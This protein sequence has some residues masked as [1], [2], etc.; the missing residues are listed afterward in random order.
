MLAFIN[1][2]KRVLL[3]QEVVEKSPIRVIRILRGI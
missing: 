3:Q 1:E 2:R